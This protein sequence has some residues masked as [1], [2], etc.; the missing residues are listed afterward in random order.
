MD[1]ITVRL[2]KP[3]KGQQLVYKAELLRETPGYRLVRALWDRPTLDLGYVVFETGDVFY[4]HYYAERWFNIFQIAAGP[5]LVGYCN[6][7]R[8][9]AARGYCYGLVV[10]L[11]CRGC[12]NGACMLN[13]LLRGAL[14][15]DHVLADVLAT[16]PA[17]D[18]V[19]GQR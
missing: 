14:V 16:G 19:V 6:K 4:E 1:S 9:V 3:G 18:E 10:S 12:D 17:R 7:P 15:V 5:Q 11:G 8:P 2:L 13:A